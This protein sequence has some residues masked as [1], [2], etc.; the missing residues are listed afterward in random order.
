MY[1]GKSFFLSFLNFKGLVFKG[2]NRKYDPNI[3][4]P[5]KVNIPKTK[6]RRCKHEN[7]KQK[8][9][10]IWKFR[11]FLSKFEVILKNVTY[12]FYEK[13]S[14]LGSHFLTKNCKNKYSIH[15]TRPFPL[16]SCFIYY[17]FSQLKVFVGRCL[18]FFFGL[19]NP[20]ILFC[21]NTV[22]FHQS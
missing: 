12:N 7:R 8:H 19:K 21:N 2:L 5:Y 13:P 20:P 1:T 17:L 9:S 15:K 22:S 14:A 18:Y 3:D 11:N 6:I 10:D 4:R 16:T